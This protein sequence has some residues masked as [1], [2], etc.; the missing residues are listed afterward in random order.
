MSMTA[1]VV[2]ANNKYKAVPQRNAVNE[3]M[4]A[5][6][7]PDGSFN[8][9]DMIKNHPNEFFVV[10]SITYYQVTKNSFHVAPPE[11]C[12]KAS[13]KY[14]EMFE[15]LEKPILRAIRNALESGEHYNVLFLYK[16]KSFF[17]TRGVFADLPEHLKKN[18]IIAAKAAHGDDYDTTALENNEAHLDTILGEGHHNIM[19]FNI[20]TFEFR[21]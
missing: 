16:V 2:K 10:L 3:V 9:D 7:R 18:A 19:N 1:F 14:G 5:E 8:F 12:V 15:L 13:A 4:N 17:L 6:L 21:K 11:I 20:T